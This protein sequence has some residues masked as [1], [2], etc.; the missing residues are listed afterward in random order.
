MSRKCTQPEIAEE[1]DL[2]V[3][4][5]QRLIADGVLDQRV[6]VK[7][8]R[9]RYI[10]HLRSYACGV[11]QSASQQPETDLE[12]GTIDYERLR[13]TR[14]QADNMEIK[15]QIARAEVAPIDLIEKVISR[16]ASEAVGILDSLPLTIKR[17]HPELSTQI[18]ESIKRQT[19]KAMNAIAASGDRI[20]PVLDEY[21]ASIEAA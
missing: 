20:E 3:R 17:K 7:E 18:I 2:S 6:S 9:I 15:N 19:V 12:P 16:T 10:R 21:I 1:I 14:A 5:V 13:L 4:Q 8:N 11:N